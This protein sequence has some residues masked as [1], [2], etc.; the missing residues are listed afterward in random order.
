[1]RTFTFPTHLRNLPYVHW[2]DC[3]DHA[4]GDTEY[5]P[6]HINGHKGVHEDEH[7]PADESWTSSEQEGPLAA[8]PIGQQSHEDGTND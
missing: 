5:E 6:G 4:N 7:D 8:D 2:C 3:I 1:M